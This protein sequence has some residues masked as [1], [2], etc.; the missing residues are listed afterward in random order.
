VEGGPGERSIVVGVLVV[1]ALVGTA[2]VTLDH[3]ERSAAPSVAAAASALTTTTAAATPES[4]TTTA[5]TASTTDVGA[6]PQTDQRP[7]A[8]GP[9]F[10][11]GVEALWQAIRQD[12]PDLGLP[13]FFPKAAYLQVKSISDPAS[14]YQNRLI[15]N[16]TQDV[17][18]LHAQL[19][20]DAANA[21]FTSI[22]VPGDQAVWVQP[23]EE[24]NKLSYWRVYGT[25]I[26]Y[27]VDGQSGSLPVTSL[28]SW[29][30]EWYVVHLGTIR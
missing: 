21:Q 26:Q 9:T 27:Q 29:R 25:T 14:D 4:T 20:P 8:S 17:H 7:T 22:T 12:Q 3:H 18:A 2:L 11:A 19:G 6:L 15:A 23:G 5:P 1:A 16:F 24:S 10:A 13:F 28:I 30:G